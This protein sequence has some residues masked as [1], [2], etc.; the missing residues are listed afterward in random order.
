[1]DTPHK[2]SQKPSR[3]GTDFASQYKPAPEGGGTSQ[4][5]GELTTAAIVVLLIMVCVFAPL[6]IDISMPMDSPI[7]AWIGGIDSDLLL[8]V[9]LV[10]G[11]ALIILAAK[12]KITRAL[13]VFL[14]IAGS[15]GA[16]VP[17]SVVLHNV[18]YGLGVML[19]GEGAFGG[20]DEPFFFILAILACP[21]VF[22]VGVVGS[23]VMLILGKLRRSS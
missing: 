10:L 14:I 13:K 22:G 1:M 9:L 15:A 8:I 11:V 7:R 3:L 4:K 20:G 2:T 18:V 16:A 17:V 6:M 19:F 5:P 23:I 12:A 21:P